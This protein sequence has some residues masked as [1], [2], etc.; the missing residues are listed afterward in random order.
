VVPPL[1]RDAEQLGDLGFRPIE[2]RQNLLA[3]EFTGMHGPRAALPPY[4]WALSRR[5]FPVAKKRSNAGSN[6][7]R[8]S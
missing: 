5:P 2:G 8:G 6:G 1:T 4:V 7:E 3:Q